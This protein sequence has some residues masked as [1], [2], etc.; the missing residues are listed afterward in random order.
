MNIFLKGTVGLFLLSLMAIG[1]LFASGRGEF[2]L[3]T[4][5]LM[6]GAP[7]EPFSVAGTVLPPDYSNDMYWAALPG[8]S[9]LAD[10]TPKGVG[11]SGQTEKLP[12]D[13]FFIHPTGLMNGP[14][15][16]SSLQ[17]TSKTEENTMWMMANQASAYNGCCQ[18]YAPRY[19]EANIF[20]YTAADGVAHRKIMRFA[21]N[22]VLAAFENFLEHR[23]QGRPFVIASHSQGS[24]HGATLLRERIDGTP[25]VD[26]MVSAYLIGGNLAS[27]EFDGLKDITICDSP[28]QLHCVVHYDTMS[29]RAAARP[30]RADNVCVNPLNWRQNGKL[31]E[32][33]EHEGAV[34]PSG[35]FQLDFFSDKFTGVEFAPL[36][37]PYPHYVSARCD[38]GVLY[39][40]D[41]EGTEFDGVIQI[42]YNYHLLDY[43]L[44]Y[45]DIRANAMLR[46]QVY[47]Q[48]LAGQ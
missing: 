34:F 9:D 1:G 22:D 47:V 10:L 29:E 8:S 18:V 42:G 45:M 11:N 28:T 24:H 26:R 44:F 46:T 35:Y 16:V 19:R 4:A 40:T 5:G 15:W 6:L 3:L 31:A 48:A 7:E 13:V 43:P 27:T 36:A 32:K 41:L 12:V 38:A 37:S 23:S 14:S 20:T 30:E 33:N 25:L 39:V 17:V 21:Y 2:L